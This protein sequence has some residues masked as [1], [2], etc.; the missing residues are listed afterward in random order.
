M[1]QIIKDKE[2]TEWI[3]ELSHPEYELSKRQLPKEV[4][5]ALPT[6]EEI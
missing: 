3:A 2:F 1:L 4:E 5:S 6:I